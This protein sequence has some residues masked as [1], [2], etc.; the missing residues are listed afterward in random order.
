MIEINNLTLKINGKIILDDISVTAN[1]GEIIGV[2]GPTGAGKTLL[3]KT[4]AG[5]MPKY[6][7]GISIN[8]EAP[9]AASGVKGARLLSWYSSDLPH[10]PDE[11]VY[12]FL[13]LSRVAYKKKFRPFSDYDRQVA[14]EYIAL[15]EL[16][17][18]RDERIGTLPDG[19]FRRVMLAHVFIR[20]SYAMLLDNPTNDLD[21]VSLKTLKKT[22]SRYVMNGNRIAVIGSNDLNFIAQTVD[23]ILVM[24]RGRIVES[25]TADIL[26][27]ELIK[28]YFGIEAVISRN[29]FS[30]KPEIHFFPDV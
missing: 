8:G 7:G 5:L 22:L 29:V 17:P 3:L 23:R 11:T 18:S 10:N 14:D 24:N 26:T 9:R 27:P 28:K 13:L 4:A 25:G 12:D 20:E 15:L 16:G 19:I 1:D 2:I 21:I 6:R 30:G